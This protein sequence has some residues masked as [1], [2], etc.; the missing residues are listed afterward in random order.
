M[1]RRRF[2]RDAANLGVSAT[3]LQYLS[4]DALAGTM[5][6]P[7]DEVLRLDSIVHA[8]GTT[9]QPHQPPEREPQYYTIPRDAWVEVE[10]A[11]DAR[12]QIEQQVA[13]MRSTGP[14]LAMVETITTGQ[15]RKKAVKVYATRIVHPDRSTTEPAVDVEELRET[16]PATVTGIAGRGTD[17]ATTVEG[18]P[19]IVTQARQRPQYYTDDYDSDVPGGCAFETEPYDPISGDSSPPNQGT[20]GTPAYDSDNNSD[21]LVTAGHLFKYFGKRTEAY[22]PYYNQYGYDHIA[23]VDG[24]KVKDWDDFDAAVLLPESGIN[25]RWKLASDSGGFQ[26]GDITGTL[27]RDRLVDEEGN[28][29]Y[30]IHHQGRTSGDEYG[31]ITGVTDWLFATDTP[32]DGGDSGGPHFK[33]RFDGSTPRYLIAGIHRGEWKTTDDP[34]SSG[35]SIATIMQEIETQWN[36]SV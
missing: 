3:A 30:N 27:G 16:L 6:D 4:Q 9:K 32:N 10:S 33:T 25:P 22:Q 28:S 1:G 5:S 35:D 14:V 12:R 20:L 8:E 21:V 13:A 23:G 34:G 36:L 29:S 26:D 31:P 15:R 18:I 11:H 24:D 17:S 2:L 7:D 19:V